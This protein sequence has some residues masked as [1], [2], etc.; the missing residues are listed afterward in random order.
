MSCW[1]LK[2]MTV[3]QLGRFGD[4]IILLPALWEIHNRTGHKPN[5]IVSQEYSSV[6][7]GASYVTA[8]PIPV[9]WVDGM[10]EAKRFA[11]EKF[12][13]FIIP[14]WWNDKTFVVPPKYRGHFSLTHHGRTYGINRSIWPN[15]MAS[16]WERLGFTQ[17][18]MMTLPLVFDR[19]TIRPSITRKKP[20]L[21]YNFTAISSPFG[22]LDELWP[23]ILRCARQGF[24]LMD[25]GKIK[26]HRIYDL[27]DLYDEAVGLL[28]CDTATL[29][30]ASA[31]TVPYIAWTQNGFLGSVPRGNCVL[32]IPYDQ[33]LQRL[34]EVKAVLELWRNARSPSQSMLVSQHA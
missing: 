21:L 4:L 29:H 26:A 17:H 15:F 16:M 2:P 6:L 13:D 28:T 18:E 32:Q 19:R 33:T 11:K 20:L 10:E 27:L 30:L 9:H 8:H 23:V 5:V 34:H 24:Q 12:V 14:A 31:S 7:E 22:Y 25:L 3:I 1:F